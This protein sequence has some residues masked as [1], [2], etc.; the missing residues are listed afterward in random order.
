MAEDKKVIVYTT[1]TCPWCHRVKDFLKTNGIS[2]TES[3]I[4]QDDA[5]R[6]KLIDLGFTGV[7]IIEIDGKHFQGFNET[8]LRE[9]LGLP[10]VTE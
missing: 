2:Y 10:P 7:P 6:Q 9:A 4:E 3:N 8:A 1:T 5:A